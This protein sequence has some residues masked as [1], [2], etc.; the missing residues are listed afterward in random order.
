MCAIPREA[1]RRLMR[2]GRRG[3][4][5]AKEVELERRGEGVPGDPGWTAAAQE[6]ME[7]SSLEGVV[8]LEIGVGGRG[9]EGAGWEEVR[10]RWRCFFCTCG[11]GWER[12]AYVGVVMVDMVMWLGE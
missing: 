2:L 6:A 10:W 7:N 1:E 4:S 9:R 8:E 11:G 12:K 5:R 3:V